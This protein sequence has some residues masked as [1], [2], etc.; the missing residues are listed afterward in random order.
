[1]RANALMA[2]VASLALAACTAPFQTPPDAQVTPL[3]PRP[4]RTALPT[5]AVQTD[6]NVT[7]NGVLALRVPTVQAGFDVN[8]TVTSV[9]VKAGQRVKPGD[10]LATL[11]DTDLRDAVEDAQ[12]TLA[13]TD[14]NIRLQAIP[15]SKEDT[16]AAKAALSSA[17]ASYAVTKSGSKNS[18]IENAR[19]SAEAAW[20]QYLA[21]QVTRD[22][23]CGTF[24]GTTTL[25]C[26]ANEAQY[27][28][29]YESMLAA[30]ASY[31][32]LLEPV[33]KNTLTQAYAPVVSAQAKVD[34]LNA[35]TSAEQRTIA[36]L[37]HEQAQAA[38]ERAQKK[39]SKATLV[40]P[41]ACVVQLVN[42]AVGGA[43]SANAFVL[44]DASRL[45]FQTTNLTERDLNGLR[46]GTRATIRLKA[47]DT[48]LTGQV[49]A[50]LAQS[51]GTQ[52]GVALFTVLIDLDAGDKLLL[53][54]M[55]GQAEIVTRP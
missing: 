16:N 32:K 6:V 18:E 30:R 31:Q 22:V 43:A 44:V 55:T 17:N 25:D 15:V 45:Q 48:A 37:Q 36:E 9:R 27:G 21:A 42:I 46:P 39:R 52:S 40:S 10:T 29:A 54:G 4:T 14:A 3:A 33:S 23:H 2:L 35:A 8:G 13:L 41:C 24:L 12:L 19:R 26:K 1:M 47:H 51:S 20:L 49:A 53:P 11:D 34:A 50:V 5:R 38:L 7:T 28:N